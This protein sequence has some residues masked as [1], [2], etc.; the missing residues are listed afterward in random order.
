MRYIVLVMYF[1]LCACQVKESLREPYYFKTK[2]VSLGSSKSFVIKK[3]GKAKFELNFK[4]HG[5]RV[6]ILEY[7]TRQMNYT[8]VYEGDDVGILPPK[9]GIQYQFRKDYKLV[10]INNRLYSIEDFVN[11]K[12]YSVRDKGEFG[13]ILDEIRRQN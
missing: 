8:P 3:I 4:K 7:N 10:F 2:G 6:S 13:I 12:Y 9:S 1:C 5:Y 11:N